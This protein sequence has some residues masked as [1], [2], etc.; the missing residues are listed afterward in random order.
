MSVVG[1]YYWAGFPF[2]NLCSDNMESTTPA[3]TYT[4]QFKNETSSTFT[5]ASL[6]EGNE[7]FYDYKYCNQNFLGAFPATGTENERTSADNGWMSDDQY[8]MVRDAFR[9]LLLF[10]FAFID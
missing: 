1:S 4:L 8:T 9:H 2:D 5:W 7:A 10:C 6:D 3:G